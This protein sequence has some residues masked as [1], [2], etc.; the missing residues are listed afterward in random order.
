M[1]AKKSTDVHERDPLLGLLKKRFERNLF[2]VLALL[3]LMAWA[4]LPSLNLGGWIFLA[5]PLAVLLYWAA[6]AIVFS[7]FARPMPANPSIEG[8]S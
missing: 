3:P 4:A 2:A 6:L 5:W 1:A 8:D 7:Y